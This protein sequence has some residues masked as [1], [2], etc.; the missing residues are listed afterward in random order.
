MSDKE[1]RDYWSPDGFIF[2]TGGYGY[3]VTLEGQTICAGKEEEI[4]SKHYK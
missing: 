1:Y 3:K 2:F 4:I